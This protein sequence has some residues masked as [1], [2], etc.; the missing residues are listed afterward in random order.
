MESSG[1]KIGRNGK[2]GK[3]EKS[4][5]NGTNEKNGKIGSIVCLGGG[6]PKELAQSLAKEEKRVDRRKKKKGDMGTKL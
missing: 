4:G 2:N 5:R 3:N 6:E 1:G